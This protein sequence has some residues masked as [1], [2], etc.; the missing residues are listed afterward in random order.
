[1]RNTYTSMKDAVITQVEAVIY[2]IITYTE[3]NVEEV[4]LPWFQTKLIKELP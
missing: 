4:A 2:H 3:A 1:M